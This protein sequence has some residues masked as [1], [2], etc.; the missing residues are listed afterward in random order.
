VN[1]LSKIRVLEVCREKLRQKMQLLSGELDELTES[2]TTETKSS[3]GDKH[4]T[5]R[6]RMQADF[7]KFSLHLAEV[8]DQYRELQLV[9]PHK[10]FSVI[11]NEC[12]VICAQRIFFLTVPLGRVEVDGNDVFVISTDSPIG[13]Q[14][15]GKKAGE[16]FVFNN[17]TYQV[18]KIL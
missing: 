2:L 13:A 11:A 3:M 17:I 9:D 15:L 8:Q 6:S 10:H 4:E 7:E 18:Q 5:S 1:S 12:L 14:L 16:V